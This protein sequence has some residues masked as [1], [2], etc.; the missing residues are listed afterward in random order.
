MK[1]LIYRG[2][3]ADVTRSDFWMLRVKAFNVLVR[4]KKIKNCNFAWMNKPYKCIWGSLERMLIG[5]GIA[6]VAGIILGVIVGNYTS[7]KYVF[8]KPT[9]SRVLR[10]SFMSSKLLFMIVIK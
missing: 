1:R 2:K 8:N 5:F 7:L 6:S 10:A 4:G 9:P 3:N